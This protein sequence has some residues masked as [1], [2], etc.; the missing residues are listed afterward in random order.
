MPIGG[1][2]QLPVTPELVHVIVLPPAF[3]ETASVPEQAPPGLLVATNVNVPEKVV[4]PVVPETV[5]LKLPLV[6][7]HVPDTVLDD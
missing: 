7:A 4:G 3:P 6:V 1:F 5:P 2:E